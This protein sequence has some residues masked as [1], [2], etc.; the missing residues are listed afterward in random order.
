M[1]VS[2]VFALKLRTGDE[3]LRRDDDD[4][5]VYELLTAIWLK[6]ENDFVLI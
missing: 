6:C 4:E 1:T 2:G 5:G 3:R